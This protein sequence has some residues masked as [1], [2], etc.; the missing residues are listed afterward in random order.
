M[1]LSKRERVRYLENIKFHAA[2]ACALMSIA[3]T[4][5]ASEFR[6]S[7]TRATASVQYAFSP[8]DRPDQLIVDSIGAARRQVLVQAFSFTHRRIA[9][10]LIDSHRRGVEVVVIAD[11]NQTAHLETSVVSNLAH[12]GVPVLLDSRHL[13]AHNK[14]VVIDPDSANCVVITGSY[15]FTQAAQ[16]AN[17]ENV[18]ILRGNLELCDAFRRNWNRHKSHALPYR[19]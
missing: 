1:T 7:N 3:G 12:S 8:E 4:P 18:V 15:N 17:A 5:A 11:K 19:R 13:A 16:S 6:T 10:A 9:R 2:I 14:I